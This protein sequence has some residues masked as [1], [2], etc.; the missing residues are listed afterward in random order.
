MKKSYLYC[1][2][3]NHLY[4]SLI[5]STDCMLTSS[6]VPARFSLDWGKDF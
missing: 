4:R 2:Q 3:G 1:S 6:E 5:L